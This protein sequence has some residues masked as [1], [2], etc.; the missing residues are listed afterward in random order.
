MQFGP[1]LLPGHVARPHRAAPTRSSFGQNRREVRLAKSAPRA[2]PD[3]PHRAA[4][5]RPPLR[6]SE[7]SK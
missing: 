1:P 7:P 2:T 6:L 4:H 5:V 3:R